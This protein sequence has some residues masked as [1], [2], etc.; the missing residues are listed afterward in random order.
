MKLTLIKSTSIILWLNLFI[1]FISL[2]ILS[3]TSFR[4][5][6]FLPLLKDIVFALIILFYLRSILPKLDKKIF[7]FISILTAVLIIGVITSESS[8]FYIILN[9][10][11]IFY[12]IFIFLIFNQIKIDELWI[13]SIWIK[14][15]WFLLVGAF[16]DFIGGELLWS[17][18][19]DIESYWINDTSNGLLEK[20]SF[21]E[22]SRAYT[23]DLLFLLDSEFRRIFSWFLEPSTF[24]S[25]M[26]YSFS[27]F[28]IQRNI[29]FS[30]ICGVLGILAFSKIAL[31]SI[32]IVPLIDK[33]K[34]KRILIIS[35]TFIL[36]LC[37]G[38]YLNSF[39]FLFH[40]S[41]SHIIG[42]YTGV[43]GAFNSILGF[44][45]GDGGNRPGSVLN[46]IVNGRYGAES[47]LGNVF[48]Q[49]SILGLIYLYGFY[50]I[51]KNNIKDFPL[52]FV[53]FVNFLLS[54]SSLGLSTFL[55]PI[56]YLAT[57]HK[58]NDK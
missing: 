1:P 52:I 24:G 18:I 48:Y 7:L 13:N 6:N 39:G 35:V 41:T 17:N 26:S 45:L 37:L 29:K 44:G 53:L 20:Q 40:G 49:S 15:T 22:S 25:F 33:L 34:N 9:I 43:E 55:L 3:V 57:K 5:Q 27:Y 46:G 11:R 8:F 4:I 54:A 10:R 32:I 51:T 21:I 30:L 2:A 12:P 16:I 42:L 36:L 19:M 23:P 58:L 31:I 28:Y 56:I 50:R 14:I 47:G 38:F